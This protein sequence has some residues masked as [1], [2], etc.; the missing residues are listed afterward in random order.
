ML[1]CGDREKDFISKD[2]KYEGDINISS[3]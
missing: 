2:I 1:T 3:C